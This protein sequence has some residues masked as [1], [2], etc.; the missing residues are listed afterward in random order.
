MC[1]MSY[2][3]LEVITQESYCCI[4]FLSTFVHLKYDYLFSTLD[5]S[6]MQLF[7]DWYVF[8][9]SPP[10]EVSSMALRWFIV[11]SA[12]TIPSTCA[13]PGEFKFWP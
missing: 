13:S 10:S 1:G 2:T 12:L 6:C 3:Q 7:F 4:G 8:H 5:A 11:I 9:E